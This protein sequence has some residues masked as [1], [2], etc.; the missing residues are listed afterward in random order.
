MNHEASVKKLKHYMTQ[1]SN[2]FNQC[3][4]HSTSFAIFVSFD[5]PVFPKLFWL[6]SQRFGWYNFYYTS[7]CKNQF[8]PKKSLK[9]WRDFFKFSVV[10]NMMPQNLDKKF[11]LVTAN[12][13]DAVLDW[14][15]LS[16]YKLDAIVC[17]TICDIFRWRCWNTKLRKYIGNSKKL[18]TAFFTVKRTFK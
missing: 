15:D 17:Y 11:C 2:R 7:F 1:N 16:V 13:F 9:A 5:S 3:C 6:L 8:T 4:E 18:F 10:R 14:Y 12:S